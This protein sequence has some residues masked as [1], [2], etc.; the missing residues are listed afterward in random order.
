MTA[1]S[2][3]EMNT[4]VQIF[5]TTFWENTRM[6]TADLLALKEEL[7]LATMVLAAGLQEFIMCNYSKTNGVKLYYL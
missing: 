5:C 2:R 7:N 3:N 1:E 4:F 6:L